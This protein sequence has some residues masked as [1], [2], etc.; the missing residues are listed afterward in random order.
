MIV[1]IDSNRR[2]VLDRI[3]KD[4]YFGFAAGEDISSIILSI[5]NSLMD[6]HALSGEDR[7]NAVV[8]LSDVND[9]V[10]HKLKE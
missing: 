2:L 5:S 8:L 6:D 4:F 10:S 9:A 7:S 1:T 3:Q